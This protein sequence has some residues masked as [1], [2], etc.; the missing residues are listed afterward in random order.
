MTAAAGS[1]IDWREV[2]RRAGPPFLVFVLLTWAI[3]GWLGARRPEPDL[4]P[5]LKRAWPMADF[6]QLPGGAWEVERRGEVIGHAAWGRAQG[7]GGAIVVALGSDATGRLA[8]AAFLEYR[9]TPDLLRSTRRLLSSLLGKT[10]DEPFELGRDLDA[11]SGATASSRGIVAAT[12]AALAALPARPAAAPPGAP[13]LVFGVAE[14]VLLL[15][16]L[17]GALC[18]N[19]AG[20][21]GAPLKALR[22]VTLLA[23]LATLG[24]LFNRPWVIAFPIQLL[25]GD[26]PSWR[27]HLYG[28]LLLGYLLLSFQRSGKNPYCPWICPFGAAQDL[29]GRPAGARGRRIPSTLLFHW[30]KR[31]LLWL[32]VL[33]GLLHRSPGAA[34][35]EVFGTAFR[36]AGS[37]FQ[38]AILVLVAATAIFFAR[39]FCHWICPVDVTEQLAGLVRVRLLRLRGRAPRAPR[40]RRPVRLPVLPARPPRDPLLR[41]RDG[42][43][44]AVGLLAAVLVVA[45]LA[46]R[47]AALGGAAEFGRMSETYVALPPP[48]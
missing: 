38:V 10:L 24:F 32:A 13:A 16:L 47:F 2:S 12:H 29:V 28:Y 21:K 48:S 20:L 5:F 22:A 27:T 37:G 35:Y 30:V 19:R 45:H 33:L 11:V 43:V 8:S 46:T 3:A 25:A 41:L 17:S 14:V 9:D 44:T 36:G 7:Y 1:R 40:E 18:G 26:W 6:R 4:L 34:S 31:V 39:P 15:L 23:S 42:W